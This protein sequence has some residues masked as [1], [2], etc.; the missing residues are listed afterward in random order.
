MCI[1]FLYNVLGWS[2]FVGM[3]T[4]FA[5]FPIPGTVAGKIQRVQKETMKRVSVCF[6]SIL[7]SEFT[8]CLDRR[9]CAGCYRK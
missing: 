6:V 1:W 4:M 9:A 7:A 2:A 3:A 8:S 5:L